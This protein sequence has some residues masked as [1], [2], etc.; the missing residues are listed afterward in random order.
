MTQHGSWYMMMLLSDGSL[1]PSWLMAAEWSPGLWCRGRSR[2]VALPPTMLASRMSRR[3]RAGDAWLHCRVLLVPCWHMFSVT[4]C[5][6]C[7]L[8][9]LALHCCRVSQMN[10]HSHLDNYCCD[11]VFSSFAR[12]ISKLLLFFSNRLLVIICKSLL[13]SVRV[14]TLKI[15]WA[16]YCKDLKCE[17]FYLIH[18]WTSSEEL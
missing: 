18:F 7:L 13:S 8:Q 10:S 17:Y 5:R 6:S 4:P 3:L 11:V 2:R 14:F 15:K 16:F 12:M 9:P 1:V